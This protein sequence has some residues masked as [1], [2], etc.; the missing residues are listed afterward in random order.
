VSN[1]PSGPLQNYSHASVEMDSLRIRSDHFLGGGGL[2]CMSLM[3]QINPEDIKQRF[4]G[5]EGQ[6]P[7][8]DSN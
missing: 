6:Q 8:L 3:C 7:S 5:T 4:N 1:L 2:M